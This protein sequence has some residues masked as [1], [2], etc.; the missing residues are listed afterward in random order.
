MI[1]KLLLFARAELLFQHLYLGALKRIPYITCPL[2]QALP[3][4][5]SVISRRVMS[6]VPK[7]FPGSILYTQC[8]S[9]DHY[10]RSSSQKRGYYWC[11][12][13]INHMVGVMSQRSHLK[14]LPFQDHWTLLKNRVPRKY[15]HKGLKT[16]MDPSS[17]PSVTFQC[18]SFHILLKARFFLLYLL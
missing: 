10:L 4:F 16:A 12:I 1:F 15:I 11:M 8:R 14:W 13:I 9:S 18:F 7:L 6:S 3:N 2:H 5:V 17:A